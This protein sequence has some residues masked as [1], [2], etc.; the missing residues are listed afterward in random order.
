MRSDPVVYYILAMILAVVLIMVGTAFVG[1]QHPQS[2]TVYYF[3]GQSCPHCM[4]I[5]SFMNM[6]IASHP[7][8]QF[9]KMEVS[10]NE[11]NNQIF[12]DMNSRLNIT[13]YGVPEV[14]VGNRVLIGEKQI[15]EELDAVLR[16]YT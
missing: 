10:Y 3:Y 16:A 1:T 8:V 13:S 14:I 11:T 2:T 15:P 5:A 4:H 7:N 12:R 9:V 6:T